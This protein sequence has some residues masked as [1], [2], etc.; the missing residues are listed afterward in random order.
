M[1]IKQRLL[2]IMLSIF[3][4]LGMTT[5]VFAK[6]AKV[7]SI[8]NAKLEE[9]IEGIIK[10]AKQGNEKL[11]NPEFLKMAGTT[12]GDWFPI[13]IGRYG[14]KDDYAAYLSAIE[15][16]I[17]ERYKDR[18]KLH[19]VKGTEWHRISLAVLAMG[20]DPTKIGTDPNGKPINLIADGS[21]NCVTKRGIKGQGINGAIW[22]LISMDSMRYE[23]PDGAKYTRDDIIKAILEEQLAD[24]GFALWG[25][26]SDID[27]TGMSI[28]AL[29][30]YYNSDKV[31]TYKSKHIKDAQ[32]N[33]IECSKTIKQIIDEGLDL[34]GKRQNNDGD[35]FSWGTENV[36]STVQI[37]TALCS[38]G[39]DCEKDSRF[40]KN[41]KTLIDGIMKY[42]NDRDGGFLH[43]YK[44]D[45]ENPSSKPDASNSMATEQTLYGLVSY[46]RLRNNM[47]NLY[48]FRSETN[49][50]EFIIKGNGNNYNIALDKD[51]QSYSL[52]IPSNVKS[53]SF[54]NIPMGPYD[55]SSIPVNSEIKA[56]DGEKIQIEI[57]NRQ[58]EVKKYE[59][60]IMVS[61][62]AMVN[63]VINAIN[64]L[65]EKITLADEKKI[66]EINDKFNKLSDTDKKKVTNIEKLNNANKKLKE[67][68]EELE[69]ENLAKLKLILDNIDRLPS[70]I[71]LD[72]KNNVSQLLIALKSLP[73]LPDKKAGCEKLESLMK[74]IEEIE[75]KVRELDNRIFS[76]IY[77]M[78]VTLKDKKAVLELKAEYQKL[79]EKDRKHV[80]NYNDVL[81]AEKVISELENNKTIVNDVFKNIMGSDEVYTFNDKTVEGKG[82]SI[83]FKGNEITD[84]E[85]SF[86]TKISFTSENYGK[87][88]DM[89]KDAVVLSFSHEGKLPG[90]A[91]ITIEVDLKDGNYYLYYFNEK[92]AKAEL[93]NEIAVKD[94]KATFE[95][96]HCSDYFI[97]ADSKLKTGTDSKAQLDDSQNGTDKE[98]TSDTDNTNIE[99]PKT[100]DN[101]KPIL[102]TVLF[103]CSGAL[104]LVLKKR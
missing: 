57:K 80:K 79:N 17:T 45:P 55:T 102:V 5:N 8:S 71:G 22:A 88:K 91:K 49:Q 68:K 1:K 53:F 60:N 42:R 78:N 4:I 90:K 83:S 69:K 66:V 41:G 54:V 62:E 12:P 99:T 29:A 77:P 85:I 98:G 27:I 37:L 47:R 103:I 81:F 63:D 100:G 23:V 84:P 32:G 18:G 76:E 72:D 3:M 16:N 97:S 61:D 48:D 59:I 26:V 21:Y 25:E 39:I 50:K 33:Y 35:Y 87:I 28:Q 34:M 73:D 65:P 36:E 93:V 7:N 43:S 19:P 56:V 94:G 51:K 31:Y 89:A 14:Y 24:G 13:G 82:Y 95:I 75:A 104:V 11:L 40:I 9:T 92:T 96:D 74:K 6:E 10:W 38:V 67:L 58:N 20:G 15:K 30:P 44:Y 101:S 46:W 52:E 2:S 64:N 70:D 86:N